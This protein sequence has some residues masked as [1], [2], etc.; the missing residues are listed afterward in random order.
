MCLFRGRRRRISEIPRGTTQSDTRD[1][2]LRGMSRAGVY[3]NPN[4]VRKTKRL[5]T[6]Y[7]T[8][9]EII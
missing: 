7:R 5:R 8:H 2:C 1:I 4:A 3:V 6:S 9:Y